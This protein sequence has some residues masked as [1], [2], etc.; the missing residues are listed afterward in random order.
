MQINVIYWTVSKISIRFGRAT[1]P[2]LQYTY[3]TLKLNFKR[4]PDCQIARY[5]KTEYAARDFE[6]HRNAA[7][8]NSTYVSFC[9][10]GLRLKSLENQ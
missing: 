6:K 8:S 2:A 4:A 3:I 5:Y 7:R 10:S 9:R 1:L